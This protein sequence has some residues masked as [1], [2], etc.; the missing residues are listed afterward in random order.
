MRR[1]GGAPN[2]EARLSTNMMPKKWP[3]NTWTST[4]GIL[5]EKCIGRASDEGSYA[6]TGIYFARFRLSNQ[7]K[8][9]IWQYGVWQ[10]CGS[11]RTRKWRSQELVCTNE[12][13]NYYLGCPETTF[14]LGLFL[15]FVGRAD[16]DWTQWK[17][18]TM[19]T[20]L[21]VSAGHVSSG[22]Q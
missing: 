15:S 3:Q 21:T 11:P 7:T 13:K 12:T 22:I 1:T 9:E 5:T 14:T 2:L 6:S 10:V 17:M 19:D 18:T 20:A 16:H 4:V 8:H